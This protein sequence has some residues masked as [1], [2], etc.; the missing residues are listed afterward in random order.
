MNKR[1][2]LLS[3]QIPAGLLFFLFVAIGS[4]QSQQEEGIPLAPRQNRRPDN[5]QRPPYKSSLDEGKET[6]SGNMMQLA[7]HQY[8][9][10]K[11]V[12]SSGKWK[13]T[14]ESIDSHPAPEWFK[15]AKF[16]MFI[17]WGLWSIAGWAPKKEN[18]AMYPDWYEYRLDTDTAFI[19]Y[20]EKNWGK[21]FK[22][23]DFIPLFTA[24][25]YHPEQ[26]AEIAREA[27]M[28]Y[29]IPFC[30][31]HGGFCLWPSSFTQ[32]DA[33]D[34]GP[35]R[36]LIQPLVESC[37][38]KGL[39][40]GFYFSIEEWEYPIL[41]TEGRMQIRMWGNDIKPY[42]LEIE[43]KC[44]GK[45][46]VNN[47]ALEYLVPQ[48]T[49][50][51]D[52]YDPDIL[53]YDGDWNTNVEAIHAY[54]IASYFYNQAEGRKE[55]AVNDRYG[56]HVG[57]KW[58]R[59]KRGDFFTNEYGDME[60]EAKQAIHAWEECRGISQSFG[61]NWQD[62]DENVITSKAFIDMFVEIVAHGGNLLLVVNLNEQGALP[63]VQENRLK[64]I[65]KWLAVNGEGIYATR[66]FY[67]YVDGTTAYT[68]SKEGHIIYAILKEWPGK[69]L[70]LKGIH[71]VKDS[72]ISMLG[73][74]HSFD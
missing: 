25:N 19:A 35:H 5:I 28:K 54:D 16:G 50:F 15:D 30:K 10:V 22:R 68:Q 27:G 46:A 43:N 59:S 67:P 13:P 23:D 33:G 24:K 69:E 14:P 1:L 47:Y 37:R 48:A 7:A 44:T 12:N 34:M 73:C 60:K 71:P 41:D 4:V 9:T 72:K 63:N 31:H 26:L 56:G 29:I 55:V 66:P 20:H 62:T 61:Y 6:F 21:D 32:R 51:I 64:D 74:D 45:I 40:F 49:E 70:N 52:K 36:D 8:E 18:G 38:E 57:E 3:K 39:K 65:G 2:H 58:Q 11:K 17:D 42:T 53:W